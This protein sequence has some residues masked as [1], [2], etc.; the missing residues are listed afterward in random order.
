MKN[1]VKYRCFFSNESTF[2]CLV[3]NGLPG[4]VVGP[5]YISVEIRPPKRSSLNF[6][7]CVETGRL[8]GLYFSVSI[9]LLLRFVDL[10]IIEA[11]ESGNTE[12]SDQWWD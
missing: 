2:F 11:K 4:F 9:L 1:N 10:D 5:T 6:F 3:F 7:C 8:V 12:S